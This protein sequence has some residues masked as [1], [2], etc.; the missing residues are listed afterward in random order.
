MKLK[1]ILCFVLSFAAVAC[2]FLVRDSVAWIDT[3]SGQ[4]LSQ[5]IAASN[6]YFEFNGNLGT[7]LEYDTMTGV[8]E[9]VTGE[10]IIPGQNLIADNGG[11]L[12]GVNYSTIDTEI[13]VLVKYD[14]YNSGT[15]SMDETE[16]TGT[17]DDIAVEFP[18]GWTKG[19]SDNYFAPSGE[20]PAL[21][22]AQVA[23]GTGVSFD[24]I[25]GIYYD[26]DETYSSL[27]AGITIIVQ[28]KQADHVSWSTLRTWVATL[29]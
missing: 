1:R 18:A 7:D 6:M 29:Q 2:M 28:A 26:V 3:S 17:G 11:K 13:R 20:L 27:N 5:D 4:P 21:T 16:Y 10:Y 14:K 9:G 15:S 23:A 19:A 8:T 22:G 12:T 24:I 25:N